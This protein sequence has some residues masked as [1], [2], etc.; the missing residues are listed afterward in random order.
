MVIWFIIGG[1]ILLCIPP[2]IDGYTGNYRFAKY[3]GV[4]IETDETSETDEINDIHKQERI[5]ILDNTLVQYNKLLDSLAVQLK[6]ETNEKKRAALLSKQITTLEK[7][8]KALEK[9][10]KLE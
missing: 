5:E 7:Y 6:E 4:Q 1:F 2:F 10:E 3:Y 9:R 8:N